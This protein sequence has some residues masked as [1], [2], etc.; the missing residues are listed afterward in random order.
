MSNAR[1]LADK[2]PHGSMVQIVNTQTGAVATTT[3][4]MPFDDTICQI[5]EGGEFMTR[6]ITPKSASN[7][8]KIDVLFNG[9]PSAVSYI[10]V[11]LFQD[12]TANA[13]AVGAHYEGAGT[14]CQVAFTYFMTA[15]TTNLTTF[16]V[17]AGQHTAG[18]MT[19]N[20]DSGARRLAG[21][22]FSSITITEIAT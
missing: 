21:I 14:Y 19:M 16:K 6:S 18:T 1:R 3:A 7:I 20:G 9:S 12:S 8:L 11:A 4:I 10:T 2:A 22:L 17:R 5:T 15:G 13:L